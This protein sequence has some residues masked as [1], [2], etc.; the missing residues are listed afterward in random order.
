MQFNLN[1][2]IDLLVQR[3]YHVSVQRKE[4]ALLLEKGA[5]EYLAE[6]ILKYRKLLGLTQKQLASTLGVSSSRVS[7][8]EQGANLP[9]SE[10]M[11]D[12][13]RVLNVSMDLLYGITQ[14]E[15]QLSKDLGFI[16]YLK[17]LGIA[18]NENHDVKEIEKIQDDQ[19]N[20][21]GELYIPD[22]SP[23]K[24][25]CI[26]Y[27]NGKELRYTNKEF[28]AFQAEIEQSIEYQLWKKNQS[29]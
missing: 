2:R 9:S 23:D 14:K 1:I 20:P 3:C 18:M 26:L 21:S 13:S 16:A 19:G 28:K 24:P 5:K 17:T 10:M 12:L 11:V 4:G 29:R 25:C 8:W 27:H 22:T 6:N 7:N 15:I